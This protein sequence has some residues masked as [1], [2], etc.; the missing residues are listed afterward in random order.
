M[1]RQKLSACLDF[2]ELHQVLVAGTTDLASISQK[3]GTES[4]TDDTKSV[5]AWTEY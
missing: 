1:A 2:P 5:A 4:I 3:S